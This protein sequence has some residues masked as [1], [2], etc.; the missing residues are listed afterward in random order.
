MLHTQSQVGNIGFG[1]S[2]ALIEKDSFASLL[3]IY[4]GELTTLRH[5]RQCQYCAG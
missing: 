5:E 1:G 2:G 4:S 3:M